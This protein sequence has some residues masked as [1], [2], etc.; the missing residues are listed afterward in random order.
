MVDPF[1][2]S[3]WFLR[4][5]IQL[6]TGKTLKRKSDVPSVM[7][8]E[9]RPPPRLLVSNIKFSVIIGACYVAIKK[10]HGIGEA[11]PCERLL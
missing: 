6:L 1:R 11:E 5:A 4:D 2:S 3:A 8:S 7:I 9:K 10:E